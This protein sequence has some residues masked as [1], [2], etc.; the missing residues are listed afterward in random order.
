MGTLWVSRRRF[1]T[2]IKRNSKRSNYSKQRQITIII[3]TW[4]QAC[5]DRR[6]SLKTTRITSRKFQACFKPTIVTAVAAAETT[7]TI[8]K[9]SRWQQLLLIF[10][11]LALT[12]VFWL[13][14]THISTLSHSKCSWSS[15][16]TPTSKKL[17]TDSK[18]LICS[19]NPKSNNYPSQKAHNCSFK[20]PS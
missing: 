18:H 14:T 5:K 15:S 10:L 13:S 6:C 8:I 19:T 7:T 1:S 20:L 3:L 16:N 2:I 17:T 4:L 11:L 12:Y 9:A